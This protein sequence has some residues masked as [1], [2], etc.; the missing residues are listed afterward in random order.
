MNL[1]EFDED[2]EDD[3]E[4]VLP[5][6]FRTALIEEENKVVIQAKPLQFKTE[7]EV[8]REAELKSSFKDYETTD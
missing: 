3:D 8:M 4:E 1:K 2:D 7:E 6:D 5:L